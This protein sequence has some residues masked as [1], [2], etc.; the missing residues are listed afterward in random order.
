MYICR[1]AYTI[2]LHCIIL[3]AAE[4]QLRGGLGDVDPLSPLLNF[5]VIENIYGILCC[6]DQLRRS[7]SIAFSTLLSLFESHVGDHIDN[8]TLKVRDG[9]ED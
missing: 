6:D 4:F 2:V 9:R 7:L 3:Q 5:S 1:S 8:A